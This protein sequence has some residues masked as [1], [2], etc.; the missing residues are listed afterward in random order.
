MCF[1]ASASFG[2]GIVLSAIGVATLKKVQSP[3]HTYF[4]SIPL[5]FAVQQ[6]S[7][8]ILWL[9]L[10]DPSRVHLQSVMTHVFLFFAQIVWPVWVPFAILMLEKQEHRKKTQKIMVGIGALVSVYLGY[11]LLTHDVTAKI[12]GQHIAYIQGY[13]QEIAIYT[14]TLYVIATIA[15]SFFSSITKM[16]V[17]G[18]AV[19][20]SYIVTA[21][22]YEDYIVSVWCFFASIISITILIIIPD[23]KKNNIQIPTLIIPSPK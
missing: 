2:A 1:S 23:T 21:V 19:L 13:P 22:F 17:L 3:S 14:G 6:F 5:L 12:I 11:C 18:I 20:I 8:G 16:W 9:C 15:P 4:A 7:E 10:P